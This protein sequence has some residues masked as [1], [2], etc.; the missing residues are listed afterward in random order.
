M[1]DTALVTQSDLHA[2][3]LARINET[4]GSL[5]ALRT[6]IK[7]EMVKGVDYGEIPG[8]KKKVKTEDGKTVEV[9]AQ[10]L[11]LAGAQKTTMYFNARPRLDVRGTELAGGHVE[12]LVVCDLIHRGTGNVIA[13]GIGSCSTM[14]SK[15]RFRNASRVCPGCGQATIFKSKEPKP[16]KGW[17]CWRNRGGCGLEFDGAAPEI[18]KQDNGKVENENIHDQ[19]NTVLKM[20]KKRAQVDAAMGLGCM[21][22]LFTQDVEDFDTYEI[23]DEGFAAGEIPLDAP[24]PAANE[25]PKA[26]PP[27]GAKRP[28]LEV[29]AEQKGRVGAEAYLKVL[30]DSEFDRAEQ[31]TEVAD[32]ARIYKELLAIPGVQ[33]PERAK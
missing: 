11:L 25:V 13:Q 23:P 8:T 22:E 21:S 6:F 15:Y 26:A 14:E 18:V 2:D 24:P 19:R 31:I 4:V 17:F 33:Q 12:Y 9:P 29:M 3:A 20:A 30:N 28:W 16:G 1:S 27:A 32:R 7:A 5:R 10:A